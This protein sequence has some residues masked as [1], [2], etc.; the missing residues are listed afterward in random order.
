MATVL[1]LRLVS[2]IAAYALALQGLLSAFAPMQATAAQSSLAVVCLGA[3]GERGTDQ[4]AGHDPTP[5]CPA[6]CP[7][8][9]CGAGFVPAGAIAAELAPQFAAA[10]QAAL[11][12]LAPDCAAVRGPQAPR[13]P[14]RT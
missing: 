12:T 14:P 6:S 8:P 7:M 9:G 2:L 4:P 13:A 3:G 10:G 11:P 1:R 5:W